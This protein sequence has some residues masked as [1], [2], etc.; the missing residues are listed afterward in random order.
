MRVSHLFMIALLGG[1]L[2]VLLSGRGQT[3][4]SDT[5]ADG[6]PAVKAHL[7][8]GAGIEWTEDGDLNIS[9]RFPSK[10]HSPQRTH[11]SDAD[12]SEREQAQS[13]PF[14]RVPD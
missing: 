2:Y 14:Y 8:R 4:E 3:D 9:L 12:A 6:L 5:N 13:N 11:E 1:I 7:P 10:G